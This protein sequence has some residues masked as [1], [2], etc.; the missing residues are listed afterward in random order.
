[1][2][3]VGGLTTELTGATESGALRWWKGPEEVASGLNVWLG[4]REIRSF[5]F[6]VWVIEPTGLVVFQLGDE[7]IDQ[8]SEYD[9]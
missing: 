9:N 7:P 8:H 5:Q 6:F 3:I 2:G 1:L 4:G